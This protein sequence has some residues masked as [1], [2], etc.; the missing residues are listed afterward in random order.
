MDIQDELAEL[1]L[2]QH[3]DVVPMYG[4]M[5]QEDL[6]KSKQVSK[7]PK[8]I[9]STNML[10]SGVTLDNLARVSTNCKVKRKVVRNDFEQ[11]LEVTLSQDEILQ[12]LG[13][14]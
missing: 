2:S 9:V 4:S 3:V 12:E 13:R 14:G 7:R 5:D 6:E 11:L 8:I 10:G 1:G